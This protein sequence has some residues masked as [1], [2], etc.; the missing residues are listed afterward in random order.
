MEEK[1]DGKN[2]KRIEDMANYFF[3][4]AE[5]VSL[6]ERL[7]FFQ[8]AFMVTAN[9]EDDELASK[10]VDL[11]YNVYRTEEDNKVAGETDGDYGKASLRAYT[12]WCFYLKSIYWQLPY[13]RVAY[14]NSGPLPKTK[15]KIVQLW[16]RQWQ[17]WACDFTDKDQEAV[18]AFNFLVSAYYGDANDGMKDRCVSKGEREGIVK[19]FRDYTDHR[20]TPEI[21]E[22]WLRQADIP[23][24]IQKIFIIARARNGGVKLLEQEIKNAEL[25]KPLNVENSSEAALEFH[26]KFCKELAE[27]DGKVQKLAEELLVSLL[28]KALKIEPIFT[29]LEN[30]ILNIY[31]EEGELPWEVKKIPNIGQSIQIVEDISAFLSKRKRA[32]R[33]ANILFSFW[34]GDSCRGNYKNVVYFG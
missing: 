25:L 7:K 9:R 19:L 29:N 11:I 30:V 1:K 3:I 12:R 27:I 13:C 28:N 18:N 31:F 21:V 14:C 26:K 8:K 23:E 4:A 32:G 17:R 5:A 16:M 33:C 2:Q 15:E 6:E 22:K 10:L 20:F 34:D 24:E